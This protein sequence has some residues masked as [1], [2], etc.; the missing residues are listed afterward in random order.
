MAT[1]GSHLYTVNAT[2]A[3]S[4]R[5]PSPGLTNTDLLVTLSL[6]PQPASQ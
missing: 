3:D 2:V 5:V 1:L 6:L 4:V